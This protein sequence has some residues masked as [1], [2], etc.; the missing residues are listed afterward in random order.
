VGL[1]A[2]ALAE[3]AGKSQINQS[4][5]FLKILGKFQKIGSLYNWGELW[6]KEMLMK[7]IKITAIYLILGVLIIIGIFSS[8]TLWK[9]KAKGA[10]QKL[11]NTTAV[12]PADADLRL[13]NIDYT[14]TRGTVKQWELEAEAASYFRERNLA[15]FEEIKLTCFSEDGGRITL[16]GKEG[17]FNTDTQIVHLSGQIL[18]TSDDGYQF[19]T[20][21][22]D[23]NASENEIFTLA[24]IELAGPKLEVR[25]QGLKLNLTDE[26]LRVNH[27]HSLIKDFNLNKNQIE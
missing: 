12:D 8:S 22:L 17:E 16:E 9:E 14:Q 19:R 4:L 7:G 10:G 27:V 3:K 1:D 2:P 15:H 20:D 21:F 13:K 24:A 26:T 25:G 5:S 6:Y 23:F 18:V 11:T